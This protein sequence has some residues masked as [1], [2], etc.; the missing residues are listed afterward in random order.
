MRRNISKAQQKPQNLY[1]YLFYVAIFHSKPHHPCSFPSLRR[2]PPIPF[3]SHI[4]VI[5]D[6][7][8]FN[9]SPCLHKTLLQ[10]RAHCK[11]FQGLPFSLFPLLRKC[12]LFSQLF[13]SHPEPMSTKGTDATLS[14]REQANIS[15]WAWWFGEQ[16]LF[17]NCEWLESVSMAL[18]ICCEV[19][20][21]WSAGAEVT[22]LW[23]SVLPHRCRYHIVEVW[24]DTAPFFA[25]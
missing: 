25:I 19:M 7:H 13:F 24:D 22:L 10:V 9:H 2:N 5:T 12:P 8:Q 3:R 20:P 23:C 14:E 4:V 21:A 6:M 17:Q 11:Y 16:L 1:P 15:W 18:Q